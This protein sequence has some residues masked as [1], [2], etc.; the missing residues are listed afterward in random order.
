M[1]GLMVKEE[2]YTY[3]RTVGTGITHLVKMRLWI[4]AEI[5]DHKHFTTMEADW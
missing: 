1:S 5:K 2:K 4:H 3:Q